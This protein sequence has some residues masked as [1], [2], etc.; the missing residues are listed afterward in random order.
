[1]D[2]KDKYRN[3]EVSGVAKKVLDRM[4]AGK[5]FEDLIDKIIV[6]PGKRKDFHFRSEKKR[7]R[8]PWRDEELACLTAGVT[9]YGTAWTK[10]KSI[11]PEKLKDRTTLDLKDKWRNMQR[12]EKRLH[13]K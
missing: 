9:K 8:T 13:E 3:L 5:D 7:K 12:A 11:N 4:A 6:T 10:I 1:M 2:L